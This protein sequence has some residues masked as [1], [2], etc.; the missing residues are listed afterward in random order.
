MQSS[1]SMR[2]FWCN[3][4]TAFVLQRN[5]TT[6]LP[7]EF[8]YFESKIARCLE[9]FSIFYAK[10]FAIHSFARNSVFIVSV[11]VCVLVLSQM[12][13]FSF[14]FLIGCQI[15]FHTTATLVIS[16]I[17]SAIRQIS[18]NVCIKYS[19]VFRL[20]GGTLDAM[21]VFHFVDILVVTDY[22]GIDGENW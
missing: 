19:K 10:S 7:S 16:T 6:P 5:D 21:A 8:V 13:H 14:D 15:S 20:R 2:C 22:S 1:T 4:S 12:F 18:R 9:Q 11:W 17:A 3:A